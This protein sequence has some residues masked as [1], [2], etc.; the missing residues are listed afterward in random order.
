MKRYDLAKLRFLVI[1]G[2]CIVL[3]LCVRPF[4]V[5]AS[6]G[7]ATS[8]GIERM[9]NG[10]YLNILYVREDPDYPDAFRIGD[11]FGV[12]LPDALRW[13]TNWSAYYSKYADVLENLTHEISGNT[14]V[15]TIQH[16]KVGKD[17]FKIPLPIEENPTVSISSYIA[18]PLNSDGDTSVSQQMPNFTT[19]SINGMNSDVPSGELSSVLVKRVAACFGPDSC[20]GY[21]V[22]KS[23]GVQ[24][25]QIHIN[26][27]VRDSIFN[28]SPRTF[29]LILEGENVSWE[30]GY[31][32]GTYDHGKVITFSTA[33]DGK[34]LNVSLNVRGGTTGGGG[35]GGGSTASLQST[36]TATVSSKGSVLVYSIPLYVRIGAA[37]VN[38]E[39]K[40]KLNPLESSISESFFT[41]ARIVDSQQLYVTEPFEEEAGNTATFA[42]RICE[43]HPGDFLDSFDTISLALPRNITF[44]RIKVTGLNGSS[45]TANM[46]KHIVANNAEFHIADINNYGVYYPES[47]DE[48]CG[49]LEFTV[50]ASIGDNCPAGDV[51]LNVK[52]TDIISECDL[53]I[54]RVVRDYTNLLGDVNGDN[55]VDAKDLTALARHVAKIETITDATLLKNADV[56]GKNG[57]TPADLTKLARYVARITQTL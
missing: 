47:P 21:F 7:V 42:F 14:V 33:S 56:D 55:A 1:A 25:G 23:Q 11:Q 31:N 13:K 40:V 57:I 46:N 6:N 28:D 44:K 39:I 8:T 17:V 48:E 22:P 4:N 20:Y 27:Y 26:S 53:K 32:Q 12:T 38:S 41:F 34:S 3:V 9:D 18:P 51:F 29:Q 49:Y 50:L 10:E 43:K 30:D 24:L 15:F 52:G 37:D 45:G 36:D 16:V 2:I 35:G 19:I 54:G 5:M